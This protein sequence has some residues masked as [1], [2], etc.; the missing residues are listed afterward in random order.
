MNSV[1][2]WILFIYCFLSIFICS[3][4]CL[5]INVIYA[6]DC[7]RIENEIK[8]LKDQLYQ[9]QL[10]KMNEEVDNQ[11]YMIGDWETYSQ[12]TQVIHQLK[13]KDRQIQ[14][15]IE[16]LEKHKALLM[17]NNHNYSH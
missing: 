6:T 1:N 16:E 17:R 2:Q 5:E 4:I 10:K 9:E 8:I 11:E 14:L 7:M 15:Q 12:K 13:E 3:K